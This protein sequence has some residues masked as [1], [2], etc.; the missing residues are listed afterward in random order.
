MALSQITAVACLKLELAVSSKL[1][2]AL[3]YITF[4]S[5]IFHHTCVIFHLISL[6]SSI[7]FC[8]IS[9]RLGHWLK[10]LNSLQK[11]V[12]GVLVIQHVCDVADF[13]GIIRQ[14]NRAMAF[15]VQYDITGEL[16]LRASLQGNCVSMRRVTSLLRSWKHRSAR[17]PS[18]CLVT[19]KDLFGWDKNP[20]W[21]VPSIHPFFCLQS[22]GSVA[23]TEWTLSN[24]PQTCILKGNFSCMDNKL[25]L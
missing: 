11:V 1:F 3:R 13:R 20:R 5:V 7:A 25:S 19:V 8:V 24:F 21:A 2:E 6:E 23:R 22:R 12:S 15:I 4:L 10:I 18:S 16:T 14:Y 17:Y 9:L